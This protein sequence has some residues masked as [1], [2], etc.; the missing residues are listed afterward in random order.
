MVIDTRKATEFTKGFIPNSLFVGIDGT[1]AVWVGTLVTNI[2]QKII[3]I[4]DE[5]REDEAITR[6]ARV[7]YDKYLAI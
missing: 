7:G 4:A 1:Y 5:G 6:L 3:I 2:N